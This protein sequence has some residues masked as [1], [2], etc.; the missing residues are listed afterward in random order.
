M[1][2]L[3]NTLLE[4]VID[5]LKVA[6]FDDIFIN[7]RHYAD[8]IIEFVESKNN[9]CIQIEFSDERNKLFHT[10]GSIK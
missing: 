5:K 2:D 10:G 7:I 4:H 6:A 9:F 8:Q 3:G 1:L